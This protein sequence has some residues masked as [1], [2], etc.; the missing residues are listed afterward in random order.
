MEMGERPSGRTLEERERR[1]GDF[2]LKT[3]RFC[4]GKKKLE[5]KTH[6]VIK[7]MK[8]SEAVKAEFGYDYTVVPCR[9]TV[10]VF[11]QDSEKDF[12]LR[13]PDND[14]SWVKWLIERE[15]KDGKS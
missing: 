14:T 4:K 5:G 10:R 3:Q 1:T 9:M 2:R 7:A 8:L 11:Y 15:I 6:A 12:I 13:I